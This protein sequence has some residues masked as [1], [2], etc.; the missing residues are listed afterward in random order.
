MNAVNQSGKI[1]R[2]RKMGDKPKSESWSF[3]DTCNVGLK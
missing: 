2:G 1:E 3:P